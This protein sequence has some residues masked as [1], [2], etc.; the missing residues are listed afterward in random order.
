MVAFLVHG[1][2][3]PGS[4]TPSISP[5]SVHRRPPQIPS[6]L[7]GTFPGSDK[8][9]LETIADV[10]DVDTQYA[11]GVVGVSRDECVT[12]A[13]RGL[14]PFNRFKAADITHTVSLAAPAWRA[15]WC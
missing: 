1:R 14:V 11:G 8:R 7:F 9:A 3:L 2:L 12:N 4:S 10:N 15:T 5:E 6:E 13:A